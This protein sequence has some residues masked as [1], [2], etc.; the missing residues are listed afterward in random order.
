MNER[1]GEGMSEK[2]WMNECKEMN[3]GMNERM[4]E[5]MNRRP[6]P[7]SLLFLLIHFRQIIANN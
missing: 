6:L 2:R 4:N 5:R 3:E 7:P 1:K